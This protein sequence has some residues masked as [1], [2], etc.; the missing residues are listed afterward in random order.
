ML[1]S[2]IISGGTSN[3]FS[4]LLSTLRQGDNPAVELIATD[5]TLVVE[6]IAPYLL[7]VFGY[8]IARI[9]A[10]EQLS[11]LSTNN[12]VDVMPNGQR[13]KDTFGAFDMAIDADPPLPE[14]LANPVL[15]RLYSLF[16]SITEQR[17]ILK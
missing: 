16:K 17:S 4:G 12:N 2:K 13:T 9:R 5:G 14:V 15:K 11:A 1:G 8:N 6:Q 3:V 10:F 7:T